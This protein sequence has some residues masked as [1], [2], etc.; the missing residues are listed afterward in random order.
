MRFH[1]KQNQWKEVYFPLTGILKES[2]GPLHG[3][4][5]RAREVLSKD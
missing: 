5:T 2:V 1:F 3:T 4:N